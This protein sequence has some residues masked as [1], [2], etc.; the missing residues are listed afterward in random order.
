MPIATRRR[1]NSSSTRGRDRASSSSLHH[2]KPAIERYFERDGALIEML[3][4][5]GNDE[6]ADGSPA[7]A[8]GRSRSPTRT[9]RGL[10][11]AVGCARKAVGDRP[12]AVLLPDELMGDSSLLAHMNGVCA[13]TGGSVVGV[14]QVARPGELVRR[15]RPGGADRRRRRDPRRRPGREAERRALPAL[16]PDRPLRADARRVRRLD[17]SLLARALQPRMAARCG[18]RQAGGRSTACSRVARR[19]R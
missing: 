12:F 15:A 18:R 3:R 10:G 7:S 17:G 9:S 13:R 2:A 14:K 5:K 11:H 16:H 8:R 4:E 6:A 1:S 19:H